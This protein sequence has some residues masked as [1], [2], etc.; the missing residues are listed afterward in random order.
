MQAM[1]SLSLKLGGR[2][3]CVVLESTWAYHQL[4]IAINQIR[5]LCHIQLVATSCSAASRST[6]LDSMSDLVGLSRFSRSSAMLI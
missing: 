1:G 6:G 4:F 5:S 2:D 3:A